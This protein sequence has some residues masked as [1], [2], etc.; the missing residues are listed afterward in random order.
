MGSLSTILPILPHLPHSTL[1]DLQLSCGHLSSAA[2]CRLLRLLPQLQYLVLERDDAV[3]PTTEVVADPAADPPTPLTHQSLNL[4]SL[5]GHSISHLRGLSEGATFPR[6]QFLSLEDISGAGNVGPLVSRCRSL[7]NL[8]L[9][10]S[11]GLSMMFT[12]GTQ[13][14]RRLKTVT[15]IYCSRITAYDVWTVARRDAR[16]AIDGELEGGIAS[17]SEASEEQDDG[18]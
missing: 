2:V 17:D 6:L 16:I 5:R 9:T 10:T 7:R 13:R 11:P 4:L 14:L 8:E 1:F 15:I 3:P 12:A 18:G